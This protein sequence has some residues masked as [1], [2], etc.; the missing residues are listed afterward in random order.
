M[1]LDFWIAA[2]SRAVITVGVIQYLKG[3]AGSIAIPAWTL[4]LALAVAGGG[5]AIAG[6]GDWMQTVTM[7]LAI[8]AVAEMTYPVIVKL[9]EAAVEAL[10]KRLAQ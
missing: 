4:R 6:G 5:V 10:R 8:V 3:F 2:V 9:P 7:G 1:G